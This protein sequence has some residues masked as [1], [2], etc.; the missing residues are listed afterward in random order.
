MML[1]N[2]LFLLSLY[3]VNG[4]LFHRTY[5][6]SQTM[7]H[8]L[9]DRNLTNCFTRMGDDWLT[10][11]CLHNEELVTIQMEILRQIHYI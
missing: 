3:V 6:L 7:F 5:D 11:K 9:Y 10:L 4:Q 1:R 8:F 2:L